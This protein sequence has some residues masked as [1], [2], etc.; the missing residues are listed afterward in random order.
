MRGCFPRID[1]RM[2]ERS[3]QFI[4]DACAGELKRGDPLTPIRGVSTDSR[5]VQPGEVFFALGGERFDAHDF[6][7]EVVQ[8]A[9]AVVVARGRAPAEPGNCAIIVVPDPRK[10][11]GLLGA[12]YRRDFDLPLITV[13]GSNGKTTTKELIAAVL[14]QK[15]AILW[16]EAS[17]NNDVGVPLTLLRLNGSHQAAVLEAGTNH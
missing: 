9:A 13:A 5:Q 1:L 8:R 11:L 7:P 2:E 6:L 16:S 4:V 17:F 12:C 15:L 10:A 14:R 3:L